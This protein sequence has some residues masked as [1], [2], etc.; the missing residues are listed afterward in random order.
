MCPGLCG[1]TATADCTT[2]LDSVFITAQ[3]IQINN[4]LRGLPEYVPFLQAL[5]PATFPDSLISSG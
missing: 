5:I 2:S 4:G 3:L 1:R